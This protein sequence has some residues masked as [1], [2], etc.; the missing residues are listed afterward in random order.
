MN[1]LQLFL[2][3]R[4]AIKLAALARELDFNPVN[5]TK[6]AAG[7]R[8]IPRHRRGDFYRLFKKYGYDPETIPKFAPAIRTKA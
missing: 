4:P 3:T 6:I 1:H 7:Q 8:D 5:L 2:S